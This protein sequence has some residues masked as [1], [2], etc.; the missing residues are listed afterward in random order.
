VYSFHGVKTCG[1]LN[2]T[3]GKVNAL[4]G[5]LLKVSLIKLVSLSSFIHLSMHSFIHAQESLPDFSEIW[6]AGRGRRVI[7]GGLPCDMI[8]GQGPRT[9]TI[10][11][12]F[13][14][15]Q[16]YCQVLLRA[17]ISYGDSVCP[18]VHLSRPGTDSRPGEIETPGL[19]HMIA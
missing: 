15:R 16:L 4:L 5:Q 18:S 17:R 7:H 12:P 1:Q 8:Q 3:S 19:P 2:L 14:A 11:F 13:Y 9:F 6:Y 10:F